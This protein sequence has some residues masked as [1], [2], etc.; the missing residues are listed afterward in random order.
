MIVRKFKKKILKYFAKNLPSYKLRIRMYK[1][2][3]Y[4]IGKQV[5]IAE[6][7]TIAEKLEDSDNLRIDDRVAIGPNVILVTSSDPNF[8]KIWDS[9]KIQRGK[10]IINSDAWIG[11]GAIILPDITIGEG[12]IVGAGAV[13]TKD[14]E[15]FTKVAGVPAKII[16]LISLK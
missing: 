2:C 14:V 10:I 6:G 15:A 3:G 11:A 16:G 13:V 9:V 8:S 12:A 7:L 4:S 5:Y 1:S